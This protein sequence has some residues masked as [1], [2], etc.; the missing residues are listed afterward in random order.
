[1][2][3]TN[4]DTG[5]ATSWKWASTERQQLQVV[6]LELSEGRQVTLSHKQSIGRLYS[7]KRKRNAP[8]PILQMRV[9]GASKVFGYAPC[10][11]WMPIGC[12]MSWMNYSLHLKQKDKAKHSLPHLENECQRSVTDFWSCILGNQNADRLQ[13]VINELLA[14]FKRTRQSKMLPTP[15]W[16]WTSMER[17]RFLV[18]HLW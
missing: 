16:K 5:P 11:I 9:N 6:N 7:Q 15:S 8:Y 13:N 12:R 18:L 14:A 17:Q 2:F 1:M 3:R 4:L 10:V